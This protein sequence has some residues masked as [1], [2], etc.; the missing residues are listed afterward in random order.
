MAPA[1]RREREGQFA[2]WTWLPR[3]KGER[4]QAGGNWTASHAVAYAARGRMEGP[5][6]I[7]DRGPF[8]PWA[9]AKG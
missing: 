2:W 7:V 9:R 5:A 3:E 4:K 6:S 1:M 8:S